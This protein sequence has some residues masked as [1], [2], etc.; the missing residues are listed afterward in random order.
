[1]RCTVALNSLNAIYSSGHIAP[2]QTLTF[3][4]SSKTLHYVLAMSDIELKLNRVNTVFTASCF[5]ANRPSQSNNGFT[6]LNFAIDNVNG[7]IYNELQDVINSNLTTYVVYRVWNCYTKDLEYELR[8]T[9]AGVEFTDTTATF[10]ASFADFLNC[11]FPKTK[12]TQYN[13]PGLKYVS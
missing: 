2:I 3:E 4:N 13:A 11:E 6:D 7:E 12:Y 5:S 1:M 9:V 10:T 8:L